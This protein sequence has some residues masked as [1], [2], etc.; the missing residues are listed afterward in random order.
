MAGGTTWE[1]ET[2]GEWD[3]GKNHCLIYLQKKKTFLIF[4]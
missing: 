4:R 1:D 3:S 2:L